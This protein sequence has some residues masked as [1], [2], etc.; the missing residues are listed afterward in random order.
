MTFYT[1]YIFYCA[2]S[3]GAVGLCL[4][5]CL[6][7][8]DASLPLPE[9]KSPSS[10]QS[11]PLWKWCDNKCRSSLAAFIPTVS[12]RSC[13][14]QGVAQGGEGGPFLLLMAGGTVVP[15]LVPAGRRARRNLCEMQMFLTWLFP[16]FL[17]L[18][19][20][21]I[22]RGCETLLQIGGVCTA[23]ELL[24]FCNFIYCIFFSFFF[25]FQSRKHASKVRL[26]YMLHPIDGGCPAKKLRS[27]NVGII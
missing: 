18:C 27:E 7:P 24:A 19:W 14:Q 11:L 6:I 21:H 8:R 12:S 10:S 26:Y 3:V 5:V 20:V 17:L 15:Q 9:A 1:T 16:P 23:M 2:A 13:R 22:S 25:F 4:C